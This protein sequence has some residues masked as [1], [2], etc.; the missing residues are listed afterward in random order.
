MNFKEFE[1]FLN[2]EV[3]AGRL[4]KDQEGRYSVSEV[5]QLFVAVKVV[6]DIFKALSDSGFTVGCL[7][8]LSE[9]SENLVI[10]AVNELIKT[11]FLRVGYVL[12]GPSA[13]VPFPFVARPETF[14]GK[15]SRTMEEENEPQKFNP[16]L[17]GSNFH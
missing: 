10:A 5:G 12:L 4:Q 1:K 3:S 8:R 14:G 9:L 17:H 11:D 2:L 16:R 13:K 15:I 6:E 7:V